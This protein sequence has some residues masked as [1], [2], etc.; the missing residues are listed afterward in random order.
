MAFRGIREY[1]MALEEHGEL[2]RVKKEVDWNLEVGAII[3]LINERKLPSPFFERIQGYSPQ[4]R[5]FGS[6]LNSY[7]KLAIALGLPAETP[8]KELER[9]YEEGKRKLVK[10]VLV[11]RSKAS[12][13]QNIDTKEQINLLKFPAPV[14]HDG[15]GGR[16]IGTWHC[17]VTKDPDTGPVNGGMS[18]LMVNSENTMVGSFRPQAHMGNHFFRKYKPR[19][20]PMPCAIAIGP[21]P[22]SG[23]VAS[24]RVALDISEPDF[25]GALRREPVELVKCETIDL[26]VPASAEIVI[27]GEISPKETAMEGPFGEYTGYSSQPS[28]LK[29][30][31]KVTAVTYRDDPILPASCVGTPVDEYHIAGCFTKSPE[32]Y[33]RLEREGIP[34]VAVTFPVQCVAAVCVVSVNTRVANVTNLPSQVASVI[35]GSEPGSNVPYIIIVDDDVDIYNMDEVMHALATKCHPWRN[36]RKTEHATTQPL[37]PFLSSYERK[38][39]LGSKA[40]FDCTWPLEWDR[41]KEVPQKISFKTAY[42][43]E[44]QDRITGNWEDYGFDKL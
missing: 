41:A 3:R 43:K 40:Y 4:Y 15:D 29:P 33:A 39:R 20:I 37:Y 8:A 23:F 6:P 32:I 44:L 2:R 1:I 36:I 31:F 10:P 5:I 28:A 22:I 24:S 25:A 14:I 12:C 34:V 38:H 11:D 18:R 42:P 17:S 16:Y 35:W 26:E 7:R 21:D 9:I 13:K 30:L 27:E 19:G